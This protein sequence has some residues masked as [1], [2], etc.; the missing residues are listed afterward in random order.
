MPGP[1]LSVSVVVR[2]VHCPPASSSTW[3]SSCLLP[4][5]VSCRGLDV[6]AETPL[7]TAR[8]LRFPGSANAD[9]ELQPKRLHRQPCRSTCVGQIHKL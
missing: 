2:Q 6:L 7:M 4:S 1:F 5:L 8:L 9:T 3:D